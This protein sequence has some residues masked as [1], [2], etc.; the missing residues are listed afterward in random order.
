MIINELLL[1]LIIPLA[2]GFVNLF[3][4]AF[5]RKGLTFIALAIGLVMVYLF[6]QRPMDSFAY[7]GQIIFSLDQLGLFVVAFIQILSFIILIFS[8]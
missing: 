8:L 5:L 1:F 6:Y 7:F 3:L 4:P 2:V